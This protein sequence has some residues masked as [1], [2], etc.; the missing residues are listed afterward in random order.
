MTRKDWVNPEVFGINKEP[1]RTFFFHFPDQPDDWRICLNGQWK[2]YWVP[3]PSQK[4][5]GF[6]TVEFDDS[7]WDVIDVPALWELNGYG[8]PYYLSHSYPPAINTKKNKIPAIDE[9]DNPVG[10]YRMEFELPDSWSEKEIFIHF[11]AVKSAFYL[12]INGQ[13]V[14]YSQASMTPAEFNIGRYVKP[15]RNLLAAEVY[16][17]SDGTYLEDQDMWFFS[18]IYRDV[19]LYAEPKVAIKDFYARTDLDSAYKNG[20]LKL[21]VD[22]KNYKTEAADKLKL[23]ATLRNLGDS[24]STPD[25]Q[26]E[27]PVDISKNSD[28][29]VREE[30][31]VK[32]PKLWSAEIPNLY[33]LELSL[34]DADE[35]LLDRVNH[36]IGFKKVEIKN[37][38]LLINGQPVLLKGVNRHDY[39]P[40]T[41]WVVPDSVYLQDILIMKQNNI[42]ALRTSH[43]P[44][45]PRL[46][47]LCDQYGIYVMDEADLETHG[48]RKHVPGSRPEWREATIDRGVRMVERDKNRACV[49]MWSLGNE[50][51]FGDNFKAQKKAMLAIDDSRP[52]HYE[53]DYQIEIADVF[54]RMYGSP[55]NFEKVGQHE[56]LSSPIIRLTSIILEDAP[57]IKVERYRDKPVVLCEYAHCM[58]NALGNFQKFMDVFEKFPQF[59]GGFIWDFVDQSI[60]VKAKDGTEKWLYGGDFGESKTNGIFCTNGIIAAD[61]TPHPAL[62]EVK[63]VYQDVSFESVHPEKGEFLVHNKNLF[64]NLDYLQFKWEL[65]ENGLIKQ[66]GI[67]DPPEVDV[68]SSA[69][70]VIPFEQDGI[71]NSKDVILTIRCLLKDDQTW[72][73]KG[74]EVA[75]DQ[76]I[77]HEQKPLIK[78]STESF[79]LKVE[80]N[81]NKIK[82]VAPKFCCTLDKSSG[83]LESYKYEDEEYFAGPL[84]PN[85]F[86]APIDNDGSVSAGLPDGFITAIVDK[87]FPDRSWQKAGNNRTVKL[88]HV[89]EN[90]SGMVRITVESGLKK[91][92]NG[93]KTVYSIYTDGKIKVENSF[94]P[95]KDLVRFGMQ[96]HIPSKYNHMSFY[97]RGPVENYIDR[98]TGSAIGIYEGKPRDFLH[99]YVRP[100][101]NGNH[102]DVRWMALKDEQGKGLVFVQADIKHLETSVWPY[103]Q[104]DLDNADHIHELP[105]RENLTVNVDYGQR[106]V[107]GDHPGIAVLHDEFKLK[108]GRQYSY[109]FWII[110]AEIFEVV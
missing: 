65:T 48:A 28:Y 70:L 4:P 29:R 50:A 66:E 89:E 80:T 57:V 11:G 24:R 69:S 33:L 20:S 3:K 37:A 5:D 106:G 19:F 26:S 99:D 12:W 93:L 62:V 92:K 91:S 94:T 39:D 42:N 60:R 108:K 35:K 52:I 107:G 105:T 36:Q 44:C 102:T 27:Y 54:S 30:I 10:S 78:E 32:S 13:K 83:C 64:T 77:I 76:F 43:Y 23:V 34:F 17:Y 61:R 8:T 21:S 25:H 1:A 73:E 101:E 88:I 96:G 59:F 71:D 103:T 47:D 41:G 100:Q 79:I 53:G 87:F 49:I 95:K 22:L 6:Y 31:L 90:M 58:G 67:L 51:G 74:F 55:M 16:R 109:A 84:V 98:K 82:I 15:G 2:F 7:G 75:F 86:R 110:P 45:D 46:Y 104:E 40:D 9:N 63:K 56:S 81:D 68:N 97:G 85:F 72:A 14:G 38:Q 18:G